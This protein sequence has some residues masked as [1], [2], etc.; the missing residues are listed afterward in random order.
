M[1]S[2][3]PLEIPHNHDGKRPT[4]RINKLSF[5]KQKILLSNEEL[6]NLEKVYKHYVEKF[7]VEIGFI[8]YL[9]NIH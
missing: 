2:K 6:L 5:G 4:L 9:L 1:K 8:N 3:L 7:G